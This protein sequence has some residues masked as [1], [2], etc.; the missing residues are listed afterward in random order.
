MDMDRRQDPNSPWRLVVVGERDEPRHHAQNGEGLD[1]Q[2]G[3]HAA[4]LEKGKG[5][6]I[7]KDIASLVSYLISYFFGGVGVEGKETQH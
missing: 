6:G 7:V 4:V 5:G 1:L 3:G 2:M